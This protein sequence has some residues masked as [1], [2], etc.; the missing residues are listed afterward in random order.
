MTQPALVITPLRLENLD[1]N[2]HGA[3][4][5][6]RMLIEA[7]ARFADVV[8]VLALV[9]RT[10]SSGDE[11]GRLSAEELR[12][13]WQVQCRVVNGEYR[14]PPV[15]GPWLLEQLRWIAS[16]RSSR[17]YAGCNSPAN[18]AALEALLARRPMLVVAHKLISQQFAGDR[19]PRGVPLLFDLDDVEYVA[20]RRHGEGFAGRR[21][22]LVAKAMV[23]SV[24]RA[25]G[26]AIRRSD[27][28]FV[29]SE[30]DRQLLESD[31][32]FAPGKIVVA[33]NSTVI[34]TREPAPA[35]PVLLF[36]GTF[37]WEA[38]VR[39]VDFFLEACWP[40]IRAAVPGARLVVVGAQPEAVSASAAP[41]PGVTF[42][43]FVP[44]VAVEYRGARAVVCPI[45]AGAGTRVKLVEAAAFG[46]AIVSTTVGAEGLGF[47]DGRHALLRDDR[48]GFA[49]ACIEVLRDDAL[50]DR[51]GRDAHAHAAAKFDRHAVVGRVVEVARRAVESASSETSRAAA[52]DGAGAG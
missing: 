50:C 31:F 13:S 5:R 39:G 21:D 24:R 35:E 7:T 25:V 26:R 20:V 30:G 43:G 4:Q 10:D 37:A 27:C 15:N 40:Q 1:V 14:E 2:R 36:V 46:K 47:E 19:V 41:P 48:D 32:R 23:P 11:A 52:L 8:D 34:H 28:T 42:R 12:A 18:V 38:N 22:R 45:L 29:C 9:G 16:Y 3:Y 6:L 51:L 17:P 44:D 33:P 49:E